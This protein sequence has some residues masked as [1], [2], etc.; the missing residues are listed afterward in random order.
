LK[1]S[2]AL[3]FAAVTL[4]A[5]V[6][7]P[8]TAAAARRHI[9]VPA[10]CDCAADEPAV[11]S[12]PASPSE[13]V[14]T[15]SG[16]REP[17]EASVST[18]AMKYLPF[19]VPAGV[20]RITIHKQFDHGPDPNATNTVD[21]GLFDPRG[22]GPGGPGFR[23]WQGGAKEDFVLTGD[24]TTSSA[25]AVP[26]PL[27]AGRWHIAQYFLKSSPAGLGYTYTI[28]FAF[29]GPK[30][31]RSAA[32]V[33]RYAPGV[34]NPAAG[35]YAGNLHAHSVHS[36]GGRSLAEMV[37]RCKANGFD[38][39]ASTEHN[40]FSAH[41]RFPEAAAANPG[42]LLLYGDELTT[43]GGHA[44]IVGQAPGAWFDFRVDPGDGRLPGV[45]EAAHRQGAL[46]TV[47]HPFATCTSCTW[48]YP[49]GEWAKAD[50]IEVWNGKWTP[51]D[52]QAVDLWDGLLKQGR[53]VWAF[54]GT[55]YHRG[56]DALVPAALVRAQNL[57][58]GAVLD[59]LRR[60]RVV[61]SESARGN[62]PRVWVTPAGEPDALPG[63]T[64]KA[65]GDTLPISVR[66]TGGRGMTVRLVWS[67]GETTLPVGETDDATLTASV[68]L[69]A[70]R[71]YV[72]AE[73]TKPDGDL[74]SLCNPLF[75]ERR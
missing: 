56:E 18:A 9:A 72:R 20:T 24:P 59:A 60:G 69:R 23:G 62:G 12:P 26:G 4:A 67:D 75:I 50:A 52:R 15:V 3:P 21:F 22:T 64:V 30:P 34:R 39:V 71:S 54:G 33:P 49:A 66:V 73:L 5:L 14:V 16:R 35:W 7:V 55:D 6:A 42:V 46:F 29:D 61:L 57:S 1:H 27:P 47:N 8:L 58:T 70:A 45:I 19:D 25:H 36:D 11:P 48:K 38:F 43:P 41:Y 13:K 74:A 31:P 63:D 40:S 2:A 32:P 65:S 17:G 37:A 44:N 28:T 51:E 10:P 53:R 68:P